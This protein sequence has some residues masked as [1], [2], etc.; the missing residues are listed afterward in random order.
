MIEVFKYK[1][2]D[3]FNPTLKAL[4]VLGGSGA[5]GEIEEQ[6]SNILNLTEEEINDI[7]RES[8]TNLIYRLA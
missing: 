8:T 6:V 2:D 3:S 1:Y 4:Q 5:V 7:H